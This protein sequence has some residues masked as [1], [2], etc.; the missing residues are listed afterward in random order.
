MITGRKVGLQLLRHGQTRYLEMCVRYSLN[1]TCAERG[2][3][4]CSMNAEGL[5]EG[6]A[7]H[8]GAAGLGRWRVVTWFWPGVSLQ[9]KTLGH[10]GKHLRHARDVHGFM[11]L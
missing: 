11:Q 6:G 2:G 3:H 4:I 1:V 5:K 8:G 10:D 9:L 7:L